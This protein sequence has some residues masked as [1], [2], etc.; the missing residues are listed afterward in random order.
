VLDKSPQRNSSMPRGQGST[1]RSSGTQAMV[2]RPP[3]VSQKLILETMFT[4]K[5]DFSQ[6]LVCGH[7]LIEECVP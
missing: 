3:M 7:R 4:I 1:S 5:E 2:V 6:A